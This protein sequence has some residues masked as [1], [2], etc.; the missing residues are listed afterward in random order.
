MTVN[1]PLITTD[2]HVAVPLSLADELPEKFRSKVARLE[3]RNDGVYLVRP[4]PGLADEDGN[5]DEGDMTTQALAAGIKV[6]PDDE[7]MLAR[8]AYGN[9]ATEANP[10]FT[11][12]DRLGEMA[13]DGVVG[14]VLIGNGGFGSLADPEVDVVWARLMNDW[15]A[16]EYRDHMHQ[17]AVGINL[18]LSSVEASVSE[19][20]RAAALGM[21][22]AL[23]PDIIPG[24]GYNQPEWEP[25]WEAAADLEVP[26]V[27]HLTG[28]RLSADDQPLR[29]EQRAPFQ[30]HDT[31]SRFAM[32][33]ASSS[34]T[35]SWFVNTGVLER[36]PKLQIVMTETSAGWLAWLMEFM[37]HYHFSRL[38]GPNGLG[39]SMRRA[40]DPNRPVPLLIDAPPSYYVKRQVK[41]TF[42]YDPVAIQ[43]R[44]RTGIDCLMW[45]NDYPHVEGVFPDSQQLV[46]K[47]FA[48]V[49]ENEIEAIVHDNAAELYRLTV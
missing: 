29:D 21:R 19:L 11:V 32:I 5:V 17:F 10:G 43:L 8:I 47:Q 40:R 45:G 1:R 36:H 2:S 9:V 37:D 39:E 20:E 41:T 12:E 18:P 3:E 48:G 13:R 49:P 15:L 24:R 7:A 31:I 35:V 30:R 23:L 27:L 33:S 44:D 25:L 14:E 28:G 46:E 16:D 38:S 26:L 42:M 4:L 34:Q 6:D 22:P